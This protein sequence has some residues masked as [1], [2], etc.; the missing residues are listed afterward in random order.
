MTIQTL[1]IAMLI[2]H[3]LE[4]GGLSASDRDVNETAIEIG[5]SVVDQVDDFVERCSTRQSAKNHS[6]PG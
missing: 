6:P 3:R 4:L 5:E 1:S 2:D